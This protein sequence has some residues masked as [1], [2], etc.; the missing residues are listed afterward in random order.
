MSTSYYYKTKITPTLI[1]QELS[2]PKLREIIFYIPYAESTGEGDILNFDNDFGE[3]S[4][5]A[6]SFYMNSKISR[7]IK[8]SFGASSPIKLY[9]KKYLESDNT[10]YIMGIKQ[11][12]S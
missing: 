2:L 10:I 11:K 12:K 7:F 5:P 9:Y 6:N 4:L 1:S 3:G 8:F